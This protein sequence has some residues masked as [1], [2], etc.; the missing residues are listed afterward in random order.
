MKKF[1]TKGTAADLVISR[2]SIW[3]SVK[4]GCK[5]EIKSDRIAINQNVHVEIKIAYKKKISINN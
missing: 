1:D 4:M 3:P 5:Q 2:S